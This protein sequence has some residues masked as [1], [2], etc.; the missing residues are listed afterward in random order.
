[1][2]LEVLKAHGGPPKP[3]ASWEAKGDLT[4]PEGK[5]SLWVD[6]LTVTNPTNTPIVVKVTGRWFFRSDQSEI[7]AEERNGN[8]EFRVEAHDVG[9]KPKVAR[10]FFDVPTFER[11]RR[12]LGF[13]KIEG[14]HR[15]I[16]I[17]DVVPSPNRRI[18]RV[19]I[20]DGQR[21]RQQLLAFVNAWRSRPLGH[22][23]ED[24][25]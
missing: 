9:P 24:G 15:Y 7:V 11:R 3:R 18:A 20:D 17:D 12:S 19:D 2:H 8:G 16:A 1:M 6:G 4:R 22:R 13:S 10:M 14:S 21:W 5:S 25:D 23:P